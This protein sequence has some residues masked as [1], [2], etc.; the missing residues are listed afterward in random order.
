MA[1]GLVWG[2]A[3]S[4]FLQR[5]GIGGKVSW[6]RFQEV[7]GN[8]KWSHFS[9]SQWEPLNGL[10]AEGT[11]PALT[12]PCKD[13]NSLDTDEK[14]SN[15]SIVSTFSP[16]EHFSNLEWAGQTDYIILA[17]FFFFFSFTAQDE[18]EEVR[19]QAGSQPLGRQGLCKTYRACIESV[20]WLCMVQMIAKE[21]GSDFL[22][23]Q[24]SLVV[25]HSW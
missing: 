23:S 2:K 13:A 7:M 18:I 4:L 22:T 25:Q 14:A 3:I 1:S 15:G 17:F 5:C 12:S 24:Q 10:I 8:W 19:G 16:T 21:A 11:L 9:I 6:R 20:P